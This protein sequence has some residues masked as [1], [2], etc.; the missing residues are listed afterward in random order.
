MSTVQAGRMPRTA[1]LAPATAAAAAAARTTATATPPAHTPAVATAHAP[2]PGAARPLETEYRPRVPIDAARAIRYQR[3][4]A[5]DPAFAVDGSV[6]WRAS[7]TPEGVAT[8][9]IRPDRSRIRAAAWGPG[10]EWALHQLPALCGGLDD[11]AGFDAGRHPLIAEVHRRH[12]D[13]RIGRT[14]LVFEAL[15]SAV[16][17]QKVTGLQAFGAWR[18]L[19]TRFGERAPGPTPKAMF[20]PPSIDGWRHIPSWAWHRAGVEPP[21][22][23][24]I[25]ETARRGASVVAA[26][27]DAGAGEAVDR[28]LMSLR[29]IGIWTSAETR[30]RALGD[31][32]AV[33]VADYHLAHEVGNA[34]TGHRVDD[35]GMLELLEPW[36][37]HRQRVIRLIYAGGV[38][39]QRRGPRLHP[40]D[41]RDR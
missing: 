2:A 5:N 39:E 25:V 19:V 13:L 37:G 10:A 11:P 28:V 14:D 20:A 16:I 36:A 3:H 22:A 30:I 21:Q 1:A 18:V 6:L 29:G 33:S 17:E 8:L 15:A 27:M 31:P 7:R 23:R 40:E 38:R 9:A 35:D 12:P 41:H 24:T 26:V 34:L 4:G 32:D